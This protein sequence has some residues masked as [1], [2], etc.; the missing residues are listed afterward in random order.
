[1]ELLTP[2]AG[3]LNSEMPFGHRDFGGKWQFVMDNLG[4]DANGVVINNKRRN[5]GQFIADFKYYVRP[6]HTEF[7]EV[8]FHRREQ[9]CVPE[10]ISCNPDPGYSPLNYESGL[11]GCPL[12]ARYAA[13]Y[14]TGVP[15]GTQDGNVPAPVAMPQ[16]N[17]ED[18]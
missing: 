15:T 3:Q 7:L 14:G 5:K 6:L 4:A 2:D 17:P 12:P 9:F 16:E 8:F 11:P 1:M 13:T 10:I 18:Q